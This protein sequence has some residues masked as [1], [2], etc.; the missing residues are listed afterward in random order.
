[1]NPILYTVATI[2]IIYYGKPPQKLTSDT[3]HASMH[4]NYKCKLIAVSSKHYPCI[5]DESNY[6]N[7]DMVQPLAGYMFCDILQLIK[8]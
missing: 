1:M 4:A 6:F 3:L 7:N 5:S 8:L 2:E